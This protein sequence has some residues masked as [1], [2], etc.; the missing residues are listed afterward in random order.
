MLCFHF[1]CLTL[2]NNICPT[3]SYKFTRCTLKQQKA[4]FP[5]IILTLWWCSCEVFPT[6]LE[7][8][9]ST[10]ILHNASTTEMFFM[11]CKNLKRIN[12]VLLLRFQWTG[13]R[14][15][16][17]RSRNFHPMWQSTSWIC[18]TASHGSSS[19]LQLAHR[20]EQEKCMPW[21]HHI[22]LMKVSKRVV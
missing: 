13:H 15:E 22:S 21:S 17:W 6:W 11:K 8:T 19:T 2:C 4:S 7:C 5:V 9:I 1:K 14:R 20:S 3:C 16:R 18:L 10:W 12:S